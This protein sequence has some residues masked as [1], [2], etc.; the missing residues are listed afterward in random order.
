[1]GHGL[2]GTWLFIVDFTVQVMLAFLFILFK[3]LL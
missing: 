3:G 2:D 1:M